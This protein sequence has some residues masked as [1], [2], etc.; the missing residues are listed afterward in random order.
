MSQQIFAYT[1]KRHLIIYKLVWKSIFIK[2]NRNIYRCLKFLNKYV[3]K[4]KYCIAKAER[5]SKNVKNRELLAIILTKTLIVSDSIGSYSMWEQLLVIQI[6]YLFIYWAG[7]FQKHSTTYFWNNHLSFDDYS[8]NMLFCPGS[9][10]QVCAL[11]PKAC[12]VSQFG[13]FWHLTFKTWRNSVAS[14][15]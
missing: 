11:D 9:F 7:L 1:S 6:K 5:F 12:S 3:W 8:L 4:Q 14:E 15:F 13:I 10:R 2:W